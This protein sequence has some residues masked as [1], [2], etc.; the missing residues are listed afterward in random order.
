M[1]YEVT[2]TVTFIVDAEDE[3]D[4]LGQIDEILSEVALDWTSPRVG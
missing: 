2:S 1:E 3:Y 4:A